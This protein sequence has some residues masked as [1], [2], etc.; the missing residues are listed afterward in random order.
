MIT[1][2][3]DIWLGTSKRYSDHLAGHR[4]FSSLSLSSCSLTISHMAC[5]NC[6]HCVADILSDGLKTQ[7]SGGN[8]E[9]QSEG[10]RVRRRI[11][12]QQSLTTLVF[13]SRPIHDRKVGG[14]LSVKGETRIW[15]HKKTKTRGGKSG[16]GGV[17][18]KAQG[19]CLGA[20][21]TE[22]HFF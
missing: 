21:Y 1:E 14:L 11:P 16:L 20:A 13:S 19:V 12:A 7:R 10:A 17:S 3:W 5:Y 6:M 22:T 2:G 8:P 9:W 4:P 15:T 18:E